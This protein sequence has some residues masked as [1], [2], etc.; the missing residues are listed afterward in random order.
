MGISPLIKL[1]T[2]CYFL[3]DKPNNVVKHI[4]KFLKSVRPE[5]PSKARKDTNLNFA[6]D[7][8]STAHPEPV[9]G[10]CVPYKNLQLSIKF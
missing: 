1:L 3:R 4:P 10:Y 9:E 7:I 6:N 8:I 5:P 2:F